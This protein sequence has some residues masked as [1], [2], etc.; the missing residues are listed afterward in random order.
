MQESGERKG[1]Q[2]EAVL[3]ALDTP[4]KIPK[5]LRRQI[6]G[7]S[8]RAYWSAWSGQLAGVDFQEVSLKIEAII[9]GVS[10]QKCDNG[11]DIWMVE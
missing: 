1:Y 6:I 11:W 2:T 4:R 3:P 10:P 9:A 8:N 5:L 7:S